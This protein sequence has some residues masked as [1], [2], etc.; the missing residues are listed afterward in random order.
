MQKE[1]K[2][3][4]GFAF[5]SCMFYVAELSNDK[6]LGLGLIFVNYNERL[7]FFCFPLRAVSDNVTQRQERSVASELQARAAEHQGSSSSMTARNRMFSCSLLRPK[8]TTRTRFCSNTSNA[9][10]NILFAAESK[11][12]L[13]T[14]S[15]VASYEER[16]RSS[17]VKKEKKTNCVE[18][19]P[20]LY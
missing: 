14:T 19:R 9:I 6:Q 2:K 5:A 10:S 11:F 20:S 3:N 16:F 18:E 8:A 15:A 7:F 12:G 1:K 13:K 4:T 17:D